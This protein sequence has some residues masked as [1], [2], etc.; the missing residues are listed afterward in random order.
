MSEF[1][2]PTLDR[3]HQDAPIFYFFAGCNQPIMFRKYIYNHLYYVSIQIYPH[4]HKKSKYG[5]PQ[6]CKLRRVP[7]SPRVPRTD[8]AQGIRSRSREVTAPPLMGGEIGEHQKSGDVF[9]AWRSLVDGE[10][11]GNLG[12]FGD[13]WRFLGFGCPVDP[14]PLWKALAAA[15]I[16]S[17]C[18]SVFART[19][20]E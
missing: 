7:T 9:W 3:L 1:R 17:R 8:A 20:V 13:F 11:Y 4:I 2:L 12:I 19:T 16:S 6:T 18:G 5:G 15:R 14:G 10:I